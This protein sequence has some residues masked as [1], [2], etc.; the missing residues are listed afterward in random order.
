MFFV[1]FLCNPANLADFPF[2]MLH[3]R[4]EN[5]NQDFRKKPSFCPRSPAKI[6]IYFLA[7]KPSLPLISGTAWDSSRGFVDGLDDLP[8]SSHCAMGGS[9]QGVHN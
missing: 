5:E 7:L 1:N 2:E 8:V 6:L 3:C 9:Y 4:T